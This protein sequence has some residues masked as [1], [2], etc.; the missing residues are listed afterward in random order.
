MGVAYGLCNTEA[1]EDS[2]AS[3]QYG[4]S[5]AEPSAIPDDS[6]YNMSTIEPK[7]AANSEPS[8]DLTDVIANTG[9]NVLRR[10][11]IDPDLVVFEDHF[12]S[13]PRDVS[14]SQQHIHESRP[15]ESETERAVP[16]SAD[17]FSSFSSRDPEAPL[18][19][20]EVR[21]ATRVLIRETVPRLAQ[22]LLSMDHEVLEHLD[23]SVELHRYHMLLAAPALRDK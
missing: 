22:H 8:E 15:T 16:L 19:N 1:G 20:V 18:R 6:E 12:S 10:N 7:A 14:R 21:D 4:I 11:S 5:M 9:A 13:D 17:A 3:S 23:L 2:E